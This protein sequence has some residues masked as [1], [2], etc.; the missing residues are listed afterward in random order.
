MLNLS[1][2]FVRPYFCDIVRILWEN[3]KITTHVG[4]DSLY[5]FF[6]IF[7]SILLLRKMR[8]F[9]LKIEKQKYLLR[10]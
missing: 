2:C 7:H 10:V 5:F 9:I 6:D 4:N 1:S 3:E 8:K